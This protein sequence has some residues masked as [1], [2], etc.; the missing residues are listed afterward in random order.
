[1]WPHLVWFLCVFIY[2]FMHLFHPLFSL[3]TE[4]RQVVPIHQNSE[5]GPE[6]IAGEGSEIQVFHEAKA[7]LYFQSAP[8]RGARLWHRWELLLPAPPLLPFQQP[9]CWRAA[10]SPHRPLVVARE[11]TGGGVKRVCFHWLMWRIQVEEADSK[12]MDQVV[13]FPSVKKKLLISCVTLNKLKSNWSTFLP[14][15]T[16]ATPKWTSALCDQVVRWSIRP[17]NLYAFIAGNCGFNAP[18]NV[19]YALPP[20]SRLSLL[21]SSPAALWN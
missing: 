8:G 7:L 1:M 2:L 18:N 11:P 17:L 16:A 13:L 21:R 4:Q 14:P 10:M 12:C 3:P 6:W 15:E 20:L 5:A 9:C 19:S